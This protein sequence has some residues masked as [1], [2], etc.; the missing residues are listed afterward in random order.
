VAGQRLYFEECSPWT[1]A[2]WVVDNTDG[3]PG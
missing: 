2:T 1:R 3:L